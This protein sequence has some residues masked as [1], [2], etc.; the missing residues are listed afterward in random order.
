[1][2]HPDRTGDVVVFS[3]PPYQFDA[4]TAGQV[5]ANAPIY[6]Q[7]GFVPNG[8]LSRYAVFA[9]AGP[10]IDKDSD[11]P[12]VTALDLAPTVAAVLGINPPAQSQGIVLDIL[13]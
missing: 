2:L 5:T 4:P 13:E 3:K 8:E 1:M 12:V 10:N 11:S 7:H 9:A 6:G